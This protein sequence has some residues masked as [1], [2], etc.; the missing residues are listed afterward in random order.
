MESMVKLVSN[1]WHGC[2][3]TKKMKY[4]SNHFVMMQYQH[5]VHRQPTASRCTGLD[6]TVHCF[7][8]QNFEL[9]QPK[10][11]YNHR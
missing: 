9:F 11:Q 6:D 7:A 2:H 10:K 8:E 4:S 5:H 1:E 3:D